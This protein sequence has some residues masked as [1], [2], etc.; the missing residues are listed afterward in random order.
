MPA[1]IRMHEAHHA[2]SIRQNAA[3]ERDYAY[4]YAY[5]QRRRRRKEQREEKTK[6]ITKTT[7]VGM[8]DEQ[9]HAERRKSIA[10][11]AGV[12]SWKK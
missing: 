5:A 4:A 3:R 10:G 8:T 2:G 7:T 11:T 6:M 12:G 9:W 1:G